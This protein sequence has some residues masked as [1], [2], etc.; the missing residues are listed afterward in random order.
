MDHFEETAMN[1]LMFLVKLMM[2]IVIL[3]VAIP[4]YVI[5]WLVR[6]VGFNGYNEGY[7]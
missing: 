7:Y 4:L 2:W 1:G 3:P 6:L 5:G